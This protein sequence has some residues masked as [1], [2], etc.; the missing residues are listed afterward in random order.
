[1][2]NLYIRQGKVDAALDV[3]QAGLKELPDDANLH[4][5]MAAILEMQGNYEAAISEYQDMLKQ[6]PGSLVVINNL[7]SLLSD[8]RTDK[9]SLEQA[10]SLAA[11]LQDSQV[12]Q[13]KRYA[14]L[15][16]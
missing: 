3:I 9:A 4:L 13:F 2:P 1:M 10:E 11:S 5:T 16:V 14:W 7:A 8:H 15:G 6:Q 12:A